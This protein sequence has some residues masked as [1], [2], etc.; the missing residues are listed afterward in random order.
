MHYNEDRVS[1]MKSTPSLIWKQRL[2]WQ[3]K[4][5]TFINLEK[6]EREQKG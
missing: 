2:D 4:R 1:R 3:E 5:Y 6:I